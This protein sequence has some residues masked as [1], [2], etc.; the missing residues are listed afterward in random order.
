MRP[1][2][3]IG[4]VDY[5][6][7][8][9]VPQ[10]AHDE[11]QRAIQAVNAALEAYD[12]QTWYQTAWARLRFGLYWATYKLRLTLAILLVTKL[13]WNDRKVWNRLGL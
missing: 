9:K 5:A 7:A 3:Q 1:S 12:R 2:R 10:L 4:F 8:P 6:E 13:G 11:R